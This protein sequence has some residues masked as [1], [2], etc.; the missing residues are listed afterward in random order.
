MS[1]EDS[2]NSGEIG[3]TMAH[4]LLQMMGWGSL[5]KGIKV[6]CIH[7]DEHDQKTHGED[8][9]FAYHSPFQEDTTEVIHISVKHNQNGYPAKPDYFKRNLKKHLEELAT[10]VE[11]GQFDPTVNQLV[12]AVGPKQRIRHLGLLIWLHSDAG[13]IDVDRRLDVSQMQIPP[14]FEEFP[15]LLIDSARASFIHTVLSDFQA[16]GFGTPSFYY[17]RLGSRPS[18]NPPRYGEILPIELVLSDI[19]PISV[20]G[21]DRPRLYLYLRE[22]FSG[23]ALAKAY[24]LAKSFGDAWVEDSDIYIGFSDY[25]NSAHENEKEIA[26]SKFRNEARR[27]TVF[28]Y[29]ANLLN[30]S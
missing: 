17:P 29:K 22:K 21:N 6:Q 10:I 25:V 16:K 26:L 13:T 20:L 9:V 11:C 12:T 5:P 7:P 3:E 19:I 14:G 8:R 18:S 4:R 23:S 1:G 15:A 2:K 24:S 30:L 27:V 28:S